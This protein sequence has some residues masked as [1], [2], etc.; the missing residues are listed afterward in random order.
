[1]RAGNDLLV[2]VTKEGLSQSLPCEMSAVLTAS[3]SERGMRG[4]AMRVAGVCVCVCVCV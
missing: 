4:G 3:C 2:V 1:M